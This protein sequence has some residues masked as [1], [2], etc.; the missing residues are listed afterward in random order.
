MKLTPFSSIPKT[1]K[2]YIKS[3]IK[4]FNKRFKNEPV[5]GYAATRNRFGIPFHMAAFVQCF[6]AMIDGI[7]S[8]EIWKILDGGFWSKVNLDFATWI[9]NIN[10]KKASLFSSFMKKNNITSQKELE[11]GMFKY[12]LNIGSYHYPFL[13]PSKTKRLAKT[14][15]YTKNVETGIFMLRTDGK[16]FMD[17]LENFA[18]QIAKKRYN[19]FSRFE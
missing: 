17:K 18:K 5:N 19:R 12:L 9:N 1:R 15:E 16:S 7:N 14:G 6:L 13:H 3:C 10:K 2:E 11:Y 4:T 8:G